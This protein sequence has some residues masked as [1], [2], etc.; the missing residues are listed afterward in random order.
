VSQSTPTN[1]TDQVVLASFAALTLVTGLVDASSYLK[2]GHVFTANMTGNIV[3]IGFGIG[4][5]KGFSIV[6][7]LVALAGFLGGA[8]L[9]GRILSTGANLRRAQLALACEIVFLGAG[10]VVSLV[11]SVGQFGVRVGVIVALGLAMGLQNAAIR[12]LGVADMATTVLTM[13]LTGIAADSTLAGGH[14][15]HFPRRGVSVVVMLLGAVIGAAL[16]RAGL[17]WPIVA[18]IVAVGVAIV[19]MRRAA[20]GAAR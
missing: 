17:A 18:A 7:S 14:N 19:L 4:G 16:S 15:V 2:L 9:G 3:F 10:I 12:K 13:T 5:A 1:D 8:T 20:A 6:A 11:G